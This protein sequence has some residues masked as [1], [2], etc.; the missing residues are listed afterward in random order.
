MTTAN[1]GPGHVVAVVGGACAGSVV[2]EILAEAGCRVVVFEQN[3]RPY[4]KIEDG[5]PRWHRKQRRQEYERIDA[6]LRRP[7]V[8]YVPMTHFGRDLDFVD[9]AS[10]WGFSLTVLCNG[11]WKD[12]PLASRTAEAAVGH[13]L[14]YQN[15]FVYWFNHK[16]ERSYDGPRYEIH[17]EAVVIGGGLASI[18]V[19]KIIQLELYAA[20]LRARGVEADV[21]EMEHAGIPRYLQKAGI[22]DPAS[23]GIRGCVLLYRRRVGDM[24]LASLAPDASEAQKAKLP[25]IREKILANAQAKFLF[26]V[27]TQRLACHVRMEDG[28]VSGLTIQ[29]TRIAENGEAIPV[30][31]EE[32]FQPARLVVSSIGS[33][34]E[35]MPG[36]Q[37]DGVYYCFRDSTHGEYAG[38]PDVFAAGNVVTGQGN[39]KASAEHGEQVAQHLVERYMAGSP[40]E[41]LGG[42]AADGALERLAAKAPLPAD[43]VAALLD[44]VRDRQRAVGYDGDYDAWIRRSMPPD[45]A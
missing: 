2:T 34:P 26:R 3:P 30:P 7:G 31:G 42:L 14:V 8:E 20:A 44:R 6:R 45:M 9:V 13:G 17:D 36:V 33:I 27:E 22:A 11:A 5:L 25:Q 41:N 23:L 37:M 32:Y 40:A 1:V 4:G 28:R 43:R 18:D 10:R 15:P 35:P 21:E 16:E 19:V 12:R 24:P 39:I 29:P 38:L